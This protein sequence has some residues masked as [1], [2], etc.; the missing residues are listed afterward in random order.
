MSEENQQIQKPQKKIRSITLADNQYHGIMRA[1]YSLGYGS[2]GT[3]LYHCHEAHISLDEELKK[4]DAKLE[5][6]LSRIK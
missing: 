4:M 6:I 3:Y 1:A 5:L 2:I